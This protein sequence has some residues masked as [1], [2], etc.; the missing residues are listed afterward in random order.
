MDDIEK[1]TIRNS[2]F[3]KR[4][5]LARARVMSAVV[6][7]ITHQIDEI[8]IILAAGLITPEQAGRDLEALGQGH[9]GVASIFYSQPDGGG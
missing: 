1:S 4:C 6:R 8:G 7:L 2:E 3:E 9:G 5:V